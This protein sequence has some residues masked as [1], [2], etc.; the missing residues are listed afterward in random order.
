MPLIKACFIF[1][2]YYS[3][4]FALGSLC[5]PAMLDNYLFCFAFGQN[6]RKRG[7]IFLY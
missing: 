3:F 4:F 2:N 7:R 1:E 6:S 5:S